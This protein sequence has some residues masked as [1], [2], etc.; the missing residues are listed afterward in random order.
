MKTDLR[1]PWL[2]RRV[3]WKKE[4]GLRGWITLRSDRDRISA[5]LGMALKKARVSSVDTDLKLEIEVAAMVLQ[6][7][8]VNDVRDSVVCD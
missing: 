6:L 4:S 3:E 2:D 8:L 1:I 7:V 5:H